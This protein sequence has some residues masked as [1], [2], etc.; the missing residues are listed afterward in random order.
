MSSDAPPHDTSL[1]P[2]SDLIIELTPDRTA[3]TLPHTG[4]DA[5]DRLLVGD[6]VGRARRGDRAASVTLVET[7]SDIG[8]SVAVAA[9]AALRPRT[10]VSVRLPEGHA[11]RSKLRRFLLRNAPR[12]MTQLALSG[13]AMSAQSAVARLPRRRLAL[14]SPSLDSLVYL[15]PVVGS[16]ASVGGAVT[17]THEVIEALTRERVRVTALTTD[18]D[19][20]EAG[21]HGWSSADWRVHAPP[22]LLMALPASAGAAADAAMLVP[23]VRLAQD[24]DAIYQRHQRFSLVGP[25]VSAITG[26]P[27]LLEYNGREDYFGE[28]WQR[29]PFLGR[30]AAL[31]RAAL[32]AADRIFVVSTVIRDDLLARGFA[33]ERVVV[34][35]NGVDPERFNRGGGEAVRRALGVDA[36]TRLLGFV[37]SFGP[38]H[39]APILAAAF[40]RL[41]AE[42]SDVRLLLVGDGPEKK[43]VRQILEAAGACP[44]VIDVGRVSAGAVP[45]YLDACDVLVAPT[46]LIPGGQRFFGS[47]TKLFE[48]MAAGRAIVASAVEQIADVLRDGESALLVPP[49]DPAALAH[50]MLR[51]ADDAELRSRLGAEARRGAVAH[52]TWRRNAQVIH[53]TFA[54]MYASRDPRREPVDDRDEKGR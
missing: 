9:A 6:A 51:L 20:P 38:W 54:E 48:Y 25:L 45:A 8:F 17:H 15:R 30:L 2:G 37:G 12:S 36:E 26:R 24:G 29:T 13:L 46:C 21:P 42:R 28:H 40:A 35:P 49:S 47:P 4:L 50:A 23:A 18:P 27:L 14:L 5:V 1:G 10:V 34:N 41:A 11:R 31:E 19:L 22:S 52:H 39:G 43:E 7:G 53:K 16:S 33:P 32:D 3:R 44:R